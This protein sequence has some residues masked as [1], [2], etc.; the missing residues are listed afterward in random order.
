MRANGGVNLG[1]GGRGK[2]LWSD[3]GCIWNRD[4][5]GYERKMCFFFLTEYPE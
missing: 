5:D 1:D 3:S 2:D 4:A